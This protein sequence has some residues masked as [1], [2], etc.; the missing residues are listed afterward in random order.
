MT[1]LI[2]YEAACRALAECKAIDEVKTWADKAA[3]MQAYGRIA[4]DK[5]LEVDAAEI[6]IRAERRLGEMLAQQKAEGGLNRG[7]A[8]KGA[9]AVVTNDRVQKPT[10]ADAGIS[11]DLSSRAQNLAAVPEAQFEAEVAGWRDRVEQEGVRVAAKLDAVGAK[12]RKEKRTL[13]GEL[14]KVQP[15]EL[16][17]YSEVDRLRDEVQELRD[18]VAD[19]HDQLAVAKASAGDESLF[20]ATLDEAHAQ[21]KTLIAENSAIKTQ[22]DAFMAE[23]AAMKKQMAWQRKQIEKQAA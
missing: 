7:A 3:A 10:L 23:N 19:L 14:A 11:K 1:Q 20:R 17:G 5:T 13:A 21:I 22:R 15:V 8:E 12:V 6:R 9:N 18:L 2:K 16:E 4:K